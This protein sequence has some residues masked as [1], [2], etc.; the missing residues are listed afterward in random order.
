MRF[1]FLSRMLWIAPILLMSSVSC[2]GSGGPDVTSGPA[3]LIP[4]AVLFGNPERAAPELSPDGTRYA[5]L[6]PDEG[7]MNIWVAD[8]GDGVGRPVT[9]DRT[10]G[11]YFY[12]WAPDGKHVL[13]LNDNEG[14]ENWALYSTNVETGEHRTIIPYKDVQVQILALA[15]SHPGEILIAMNKRDPLAHDVYR[16]DI[17]SGTPTLVAENPGNVR[18]WITDGDLRVRGMH[19]SQQDGSFDFL[20]RDTEESEW[21]NVAHWELEDAITSRPI[22]FSKDGQYAYLLDSRGA[23]TGRL[24]Q[25]DLSSGEIE[26]LA[27]DPEYDLGDVFGVDLMRHPETDALQAVIY[28]RDRI[29]WKLLDASLEKDIEQLRALQAGDFQITSRSRDDRVWFVKFETDTG[30]ITNYAYDRDTQQATL[31]F[32]SIPELKDYS[33]AEME[34]FRYEARDGLTLHGYITFPR[35]VPR[36]HLPMVINPHGGPWYRDKWGYNPEVQWLANRGY[37][38]LNVNFRSSTTYGKESIN[39][40]DHEWGRNMLFD[41]ID[42]AEWAVEQGYADPER[43]GIYGGSYGGYQALCASTFTPE[44]FTCAID[45]VGPSNLI[46]FMNAF[47]PQWETRKPRFYLR[48]GHPERDQEMLRERSPYFHAD[49]I[50]IPILIAQGAND[51]RVKQAES[52]QIVAKLEENGVE[53]EYLLFEDEGHGFAHPDNRETFYSAA[54]AFLAKHLGGRQESESTSNMRLTSE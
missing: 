44:F 26:V 47:P 25:L 37:I 29:A 18:F 3:E 22:G 39:A 38:C 48:G 30:P 27:E 28:F 42:A 34:P 1:F 9:N 52:D 31:L 43:I 35:G 50:R 15:A 45:V 21:R 4:R 33:L 12:F 11:L 13:Y 17:E 16:L 10:R 46:T 49:R 8:I 14:D 24:C 53:H 51:P 2:T 32:E 20:I 36:E 23:K 41:L 19:L 5:Y 6:A 54:E 7:V 40:G